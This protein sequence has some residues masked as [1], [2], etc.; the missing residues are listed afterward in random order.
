MNLLGYFEVTHVDKPISKDELL[1]K[2]Y[3][4]VSISE[5]MG[6]IK[7]INE[8]KKWFEKADNKQCLVVTGTHGCGK[9]QLVKLFCKKYAIHTYTLDDVP[10]KS[11]KE[12]ANFITQIKNFSQCVLLLDDFEMILTKGECLSIADLNKT[13]IQESSMKVIILINEVY[14]SK[15]SLIS[16]CSRFVPLTLPDQKQIFRKCLHIFQCENIDHSD[17]DLIIL[18]DFITKKA[19]DVRSI[20]D[21]L[22]MFKDVSHETI[23]KDI[24][25]YTAYS[26][27]TDPN[28]SIQNKC[29]HF[30]SDSGTIPI[31]CQ[32]NYIDKITCLKTL[33]KI[34]NNFSL[35]DVY[36]KA[37][38]TYNHHMCT[39]VYGSLSCFHLHEHK[40]LLNTKPRFGLIWT[41][42]SAM[43]QKRKYINEYVMNEK[44]PFV[45][46]A[47]LFYMSMNIKQLTQ[48]KKEIHVSFRHVNVENLFNL[49]NAFNNHENILKQL[50]KKTFV[51]YMK[52]YVKNDLL[53]KFKTHIVNM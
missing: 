46:I 8:I 28:V 47:K 30:S 7:Q 12:F 16:S 41:K 37:S 22:R 10:K 4:P 50:S 13:F 20:F 42:Q 15:L 53:N 45:N 52:K 19:C 25:M 11:K 29:I 21:S 44:N 51:S 17:A 1:S 2:K 38:F 18:K 35:G 39:D 9:T 40:H 49:Y 24:D 43:Y 48:D 14:I 31:I 33:T 26:L 27:C 5:W 3:S 23:I 36:H 34:S 6:N 32:E